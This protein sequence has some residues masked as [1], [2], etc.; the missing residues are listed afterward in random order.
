MWKITRE[1]HMRT[2]IDE[3]HLEKKCQFFDTYVQII[4]LE[5]TGAFK[6]NSFYHVA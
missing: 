1:S 5:Y 6:K 2:F 4:P 3:K